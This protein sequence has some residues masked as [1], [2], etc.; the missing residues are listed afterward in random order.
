MNLSSNDPANAMQIKPKTEAPQEK[1]LTPLMKQFWEIKNQHQDKI[2]LFRM[3]DFYEMF[4]EDAKKA[5]PVLNIALTQR[6]KKSADDTAMCGVPHHSISGPINK[7]LKAQFKVAICE[8]MEDPKEAK[9]IVKRAVTRILT[10][11]MVYDP[12]TLEES[13][14]NYIASFDAKAVAFFDSSTGTSFFIPCKSRDERDVLLSMFQPVEIVLSEAHGLSERELAEFRDQ[15]KI[16]SFFDS[17][18]LS[19]KLEQ[20]L[21]QFMR[22][23]SFSSQGICESLKLL[24]SYGA[25]LAGEEFFKTLKVPFEK[26]MKSHFF[27]SENVQRHLEIFQNN[28]GEESPTFFSAV[29]R[30]QTSGGRRLLRSWILTPLLDEKEI[31]QRQ[32]RIQFWRDRFLDLKKMREIFPKVGDLER[33]FVKLTSTQVNGRDVLS[34]N[35]SLRS[36]LEISKRVFEWSRSPHLSEQFLPLESL[37]V[38][39]EE[40]LVDEP[41]LL[42]RQGSL[43]RKGFRADLD[44]LITL[45]TDSHEILQKMELREREATGI[46]SLK[47]RYNQVFGYYIEVTHTHKDKVPSHY[48]RKQTLATAERFC[49]EELLELEKK[50]LS[51]Q[52]RRFELEWTIF[53]DLRKKILAHSTLIQSLADHVS[54]WDVESS[55]A[56]L[57]L[58]E[59]YCRPQVSESLEI[60]QARH[61]VLDQTLK[62]RFIANDLVMGEQKVLLLTGPNMAGKSTLMRQVGLI[63]LLHQMG[64]FVPA[65]EAKIPLFDQIYT[66]IGANDQLSAGLST[67]MVEMKE[68]GELLELATSKS[69]VI[70]DEIGR[71]TATFDGMSLAEAIL[72]YLLSETKALTLFATHYHELTVLEERFSNLRNVH[73]SVRENRGDLTF[74]YILKKGPALKSYGIAVARLAG[75]P[76]SVLQSAQ[77]RLNTLE[78]KASEAL[79]TRQ[80]SFEDWQHHEVATNEIQSESDEKLRAEKEKLQNQLNEYELFIQSLIA[81]DVNLKTPL[82]GLTL[83]GDL[84]EKAKELGSS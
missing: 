13:K 7:L 35:S 83:L 20:D 40:T 11:G 60:R 50:I 73:M 65:V 44:E 18:K 27:L 84:Q 77:K 46:T 79:G 45:T 41:P 19:A 55:L 22:D 3:G 28:R 56:W 23:Q 70:L 81:I 34:L 26:Q 64:S 25:F 59:G 76:S 12:E 29:N 2:L 17:G 57:S 39:I 1:S 62:G 38:E 33:R 72:E 78:R 52:S 15:G 21:E 4:D 37:C 61:V 66:R 9:G 80:V 31:L 16:L 32:D 53:E 42:T 48:Q 63:A 51:A 58:E 69:L 43:I 54:L 74:E 75:L 6:N 14:A 82:Q 30:A 68:T 71:G 49:T 5:A 36:S 10:P 24:L 8:Q 67:F 47:I